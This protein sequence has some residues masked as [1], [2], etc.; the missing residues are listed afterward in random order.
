MSTRCQIGYYRTFETDYPEILIYK[1]SDGYPSDTLVAIADFL[2]EFIP[3]RGVDDPEYLMAQLLVSLVNRANRDRE[4]FERKFYQDKPGYVYEPGP[5]RFLGFGICGDRRLHWDIEYLYCITPAG[6]QCYGVERVSESGA[7]LGK[8][9]LTPRQAKAVL[10][11]TV[12]K[13]IRES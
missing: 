2:R 7:V 11:G 6:V 9:I 4:D 1:H 10:K 12:P 13:S 3:A 5:Y 8:P